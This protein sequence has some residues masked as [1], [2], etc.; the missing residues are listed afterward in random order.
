[1]FKKVLISNRGEIALRIIRACRELGIGTVAVYSEADD[2]SLHKKFADEAICIGP[3]DPSKSYLN[4]PAIISAAELTNA[5]AIHPGYGFL[6]E[7]PEFSSICNENNITFIG[8]DHDTI[9]KMGNKSVAKKTMEDNGLPV[10]PGSKGN[11]DNFE[12]GVRIASKIG[13]PVIIKAA[14]GGGGRGMRLVEKE[15]DFKHAFE[16]AQ[17]EA[18]ISFNDS[19]VYL[20]KYFINTKHIE[21]QIISDSHGNVYSL[22]ERECS[23]QRRHQKIIEESPSLAINEVLRNDIQKKS[24]EVIKKVGYI[25]VGTIEYLFDID[26][27]NYFFMEM[28]TRIQV[29]HPV[30]EFVTSFDLI[31]N[32]ILCHTGFSLPSWLSDIK[33]RGH[34]IEC[35]INAEDPDNNFMPSPGLITSFHMPGGMGVRID[36]HVYSGYTVP[37]NYDSMIAKVIVNAHDRNEAIRRMLGALD[38]CVIEGIKTTIPFQKNILSNEDFKSGNFNTNFLN[39]LM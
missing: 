24:V 9:E 19:N 25:G 2:L 1:M 3:A 11:I 6:S 15:S 23:I 22:G 5:D 16:T 38:E 29:E 26:T 36:T 12:E 32:Q 37:S 17:S 39:Q 34:S 21:I 7:N 4:I 14:S 35:R 27:S 33:T 30:T 28:N 18:K 31:K 8:P 13:Y 20:E 10:I